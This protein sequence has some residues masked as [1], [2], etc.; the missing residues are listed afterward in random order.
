MVQGWLY[1][2]V[3]FAGTFDRLHSGHKHLLHAA[4]EFG[5]HVAI[6]LTSDE[7]IQAKSG[8]SAILSYEERQSALLMFLNKECDPNRYSIFQ[9]NTVEG[10]ADTMDDLE[11]LIVS[12][13]IKV[14]ENAFKINDKREENGL[15]KFHIIV[16][17]RVRTEDGRPLS[18]SRIRA[19]EELSGKKLV[20]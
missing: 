14:V 16:I 2:K 19:G 18:S 11:A 12:D 9:I 1:R 7:M 4:F 10:G 8:S 5:A 3:V 6:G 20:Y 13:E 15:K 17:P